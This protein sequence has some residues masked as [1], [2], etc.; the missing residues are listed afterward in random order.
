[1][2]DDGVPLLRL[3]LSAIDSDKITICCFRMG[4]GCCCRV[5]AVEDVTINWG[6]HPASKGIS[7]L[8][9]MLNYTLGGASNYTLGG[10]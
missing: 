2:D 4:F 1:M 8:P 6:G 5:D 7:S 9:P 3:T 10:T